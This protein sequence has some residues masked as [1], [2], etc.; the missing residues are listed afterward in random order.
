[1]ISFYLI[2]GGAIDTVREGFEECEEFSA[3]RQM[4]I[5]N[6]KYSVHPIDIEVQSV[7]R[8]KIPDDG[9]LTEFVNQLISSDVFEKEARKFAWEPISAAI[10]HLLSELCI[11]EKNFERITQI[12][13]ERLHSKEH[14]AQKKIAQ[15]NVHVQKGSLLQITFKGDGRFFVLFVKVQLTQFLGESNYKKQNGYPLENTVLKMALVDFEDSCSPGRV[16]ISDSNAKIAEYWWKDFLELQELTTNEYNTKTALDS[17]DGLLG[18]KLKK[19]SPADYYQLRNN[20]IGYFRNNKHYNHSR[21]L[22]HVFGDYHP[23]DSR[24]KIDDLRCA[25][26][27]LPKKQKFDTK[28]DIQSELVNKRRKTIIALTTQI[29]L[30]IKDALENMMDTI[31]P[32]TLEDGTEGVFI[33]SS[34]GYKYFG[35]EITGTSATVATLQ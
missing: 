8:E 20:L 4:K 12:F 26:M 7:E 10:P 22:T 2:P 24:V 21:M 14:D 13:A 16:L 29:D 30:E 28:F 9:D 35:A 3:L 27:E 17:M 25:A 18:R 19:D 32:A 31:K 11:D 6:L 5:T 34:D 23:V 33:R 1:M 15:L